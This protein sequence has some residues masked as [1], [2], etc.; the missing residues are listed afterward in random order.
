M[1]WRSACIMMAS[2]Y[3]SCLADGT[4]NRAEFLALPSSWPSGLF[5]LGLGEKP[6]F[7]P[8][9]RRGVVV[10]GWEG[11]G[12][13]S[14]RSHVQY[15]SGFIRGSSPELGGSQRGTQTPS[16]GLRHPPFNYGI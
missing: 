4:R 10:S 6:S 15:F 16:I 14:R 3:A 1:V 2:N 11:S 7:V 5:Q 12:F 8:A 9:G 13:Q